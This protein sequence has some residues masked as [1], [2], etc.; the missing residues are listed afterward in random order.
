M[1]IRSFLRI[2][3]SPVFLAAVCYASAGRGACLLSIGKGDVMG[4]MVAVAVIA[5]AL[6]F[7]LGWVVGSRRRKIEADLDALW[8]DAY[9]ENAQVDLEAMRKKAMTIVRL[10]NEIATTAT[11][12]HETVL[13]THGILEPPALPANAPLQD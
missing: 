3:A 10:A 5:V 7:G 4:V 8:C 12:A 6:G 1:K 9:R 2:R 11:Q 13:K